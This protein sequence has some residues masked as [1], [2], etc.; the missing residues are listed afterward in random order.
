MTKLLLPSL[1]TLLI[2]AS[3]SPVFADEDT[4][5]KEGETPQQRD[6]RVA[7]QAGHYAGGLRVM[8]ASAGPDSFNFIG[9]TPWAR[10]NVSDAI[11]V[12]ARVPLAV[13]KPEGFGAFGGMMARVELRLGATIG[14][15]AEAGFLKHGAVLLTDQDAPIYVDD[16]DY[17]FAARIGPW[18]RVKGGPVYLS[19]DPA[20]AYQAGDP[21]ITG[22]QFPV[23]ALFRAGTV[24]HAGAQV[25]IYTG[26]DFKMGA[27]EGGRVAAGLVADVKV[28]SIKVM[29]GAGVSSLLTD[30]M[31]LYTSVGKSLYV[32]VN[33]A[34]V[35]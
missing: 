6:D 33:L 11:N 5:V 18:V 19:F 30:D 24:A 13:S 15:F 20:F 9:V 3:V 23:T 25:G 22:I 2:T 21:G 12:G 35:K 26:D 14:A 8:F 31:G 4:D 29:L 32:S 10:Y 34:Y 7:G 16:A 27:D 17:D 28:S 1:A